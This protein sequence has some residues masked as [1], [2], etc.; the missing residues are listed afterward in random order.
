MKKIFTV[1]FAFTFF[2][3][4][5]QIQKNNKSK[6]SI[7]Q[8]MQDPDEWVGF[9]PDRINWSENSENIYF[10]WN[11]EQD[12]F[13]SLYAYS[14]KTKKTEKVSIEEQQK[15]PSRGTYN[16]NKTKQVFIRDGN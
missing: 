16:T 2:V 5:A 14:L 11:P 1:L 13:P 7:E 9:S 3:S 8:I 12:T 4:F 15:I 10:N 6:L